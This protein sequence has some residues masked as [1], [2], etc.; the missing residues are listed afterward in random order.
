MKEKWTV[1][2]LTMG[3]LFPLSACSGEGGADA[4][5]AALSVRGAYLSMSGCSG[6]LEVTADYGQ[7]VYTYGMA[8]DWSRD[9]ETVLELTSPEEVAGLRARLTEEGGALEYD[10]VSVETGPLTG[11]G[12]SPMEAP[13]A[14]LDGVREGYLASTGLETVDEREE[15]HLVIRAPEGVPGTGTELEVWCDPET[16]ALLRGEILSDGRTVVTCEFQSFTMEGGEEK[17]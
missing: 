3:L 5:G 11:E 2:V 16:G 13:L 7:R 12:L 9:G 6:T 4:D 8:L 10:G 17:N 15:L 1:L 14:L